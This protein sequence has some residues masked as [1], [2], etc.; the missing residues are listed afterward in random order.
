VSDAV[1]VALAN[2]SFNPEPT[3]TASFLESMLRAA[4]AGRGGRPLETNLTLSNLKIRKN[5]VA[6][7]SRSNNY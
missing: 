3:T 6:V 2:G 5:A 4:P 1:K 7:G